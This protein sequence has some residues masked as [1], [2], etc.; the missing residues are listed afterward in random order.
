MYR[1]FYTAIKS[2][3]FLNIF[4]FL[5]LPKYTYVCTCVCSHFWEICF[6]NLQH[7]FEVIKL[8][9]EMLFKIHFKLF[10]W[11]FLVNSSKLIN[12]F[13]WFF[14]SKTTKNGQFFIVFQNW[15]VIK[16]YV[17]KGFIYFRILSIYMNFSLF[18]SKI[19]VTAITA[20]KISLTLEKSQID[21][22][23]I[24]FLHTNWWGKI[25]QFCWILLFVSI[26]FSL[27]KIFNISQWLVEAGK[28]NH[29]ETN[30]KLEQNC[31]KINETN[32]L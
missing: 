22:I 1:H 11:H 31:S 15:N 21:L 5:F 30:L 4:F 29:F 12:I 2:N 19:L 24:W 13:V 18:G 23:F 25:W 16:I 7:Q 3:N 10:S 20:K 8:F 14:F 6:I 32:F 17:C 26:N 9:L 27:F 28:G